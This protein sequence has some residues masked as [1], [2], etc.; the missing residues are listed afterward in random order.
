VNKLHRHAILY[1]IP[2]R[3]S[4]ILAAVSPE[5]LREHA[6]RLGLSVPAYRNVVP[7]TITERKSRIDI[8]EEDA[9]LPQ[10]TPTA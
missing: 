8:P 10:T 5:A 4:F 2:G 3:G 9:T 7:V 1:E 6:T